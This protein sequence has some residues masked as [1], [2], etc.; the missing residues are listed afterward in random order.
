[1]ENCLDIEDITAYE[2][3]GMMA[4]KQS[5]PG[6]VWGSILDAHWYEASLPHRHFVQILHNMQTA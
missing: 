3:P 1:M 2:V 4:M 5:G 6:A